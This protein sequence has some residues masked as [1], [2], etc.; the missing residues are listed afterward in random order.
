MK[1]ILSFIFIVFSFTMLFIGCSS[2]ALK[3]NFIE[4]VVTLDGSP[5]A[6]ATITF[7][8]K[9][10]EPVAV[11]KTDSSGKYTLSSLQGGRNGQGALSGDYYVTIKKMIN[12]APKPT[13][14]ELR[15]ASEKGIDLTMKYP[16]K[17]E[18][19]IPS[20]YEDKKT[21]GLEATVKAGKNKI[22]FDLTSK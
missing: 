19:V 3:T 20:K 15:N 17:M 2:N 6:D 16:S 22:D 4:G 11:G 10:N 12:T 21:S 1:K 14:E 8:P 5:V 18:Y 7:S 13:E 9:G